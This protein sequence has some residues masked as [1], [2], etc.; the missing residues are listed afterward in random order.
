MTGDKNATR[1]S[2]HKLPGM[3]AVAVQKILSCFSCDHPPTHN[4]PGKHPIYCAGHATRGMVDII[5]S[6]RCAITTCPERPFAAYESHY[7]C[8]IHYPNDSA[9]DDSIRKCQIHELGKG[10]F[11]CIDCQARAHKKEW[12]R[13]WH[14]LP[15]TQIIT[16]EVIHGNV[17]RIEAF[18]K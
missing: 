5:S 6:S 4:F 2:E 9:R 17:T 16:A 7:Y 8:A 18:S 10:T 13:Q 1:C 3:V 11:V 15:E 12:A 14:L